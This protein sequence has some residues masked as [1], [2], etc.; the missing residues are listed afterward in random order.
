MNLNTSNNPDPEGG[1][2]PLDADLLPL[3]ADLDRLALIERSA[4]AP[5]LEDRLMLSTLASLHGV[6]PTAAQVAELASLDRASAPRNLEE[7]VFESSLPTL[8][9]NA[10]ATPRLV[11]HSG[12]QT[13][14]ARRH[15]RQAWWS[16]SPIRLAAMI[17]FVAGAAIAVRV[18]ITTNPTAPSSDMSERVKGEMDMLFAAMDA[19]TSSDAPTEP[20]I[21]SQTDDLTTWLLDGASS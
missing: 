17:V 4:A 11:L 20:T 21:D 16:R 8:R 1:A 12:D 19:R 2:T 5:G 6:Q 14:D 15:V 9:E 10:S 13:S 7:T 18:G 3:M